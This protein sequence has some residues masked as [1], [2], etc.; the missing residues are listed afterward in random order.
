MSLLL[1][2]TDTHLFADPEGQLKG[3]ATRESFAAVTAKA[4]EAFPDCDAVILGGDLAQDQSKEAYRSIARVML[5]CDAPVHAIVGN[6][7]DPV[8]MKEALNPTV[9]FKNST[10]ALRLGGWQI[11]LLN[12][13]DAGK[14]S[15][16]LSE[17]DLEKLDALMR[18]GKDLHQLI[19]IH[20]HP[21]PVGSA[22]MDNIMVANSEAFWQVADKHDS[23]RGVLFG[24]VH[25]AFDDMRNNVRLLGSPSTTVQFKPGEDDFLMDNLSPGYRWLKLLD[26][27]SIETGVERVEGFIPDDLLDLTGY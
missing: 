1:H 4:C 17:A 2:I 13:Q 19:V 18:E 15:G 5:D 21:I 3:L 27:G 11:L 22:W 23:L 8:V 7:D 14:V 20:H 6:H 12:S 26:D 16:R 25:Q 9:R 24:H 10:S